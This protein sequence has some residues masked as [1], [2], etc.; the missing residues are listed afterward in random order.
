MLWFPSHPQIHLIIT[1]LWLKPLLWKDS[2]LHFVGLKVNLMQ[3]LSLIVY[4][5][6]F[7]WQS[8]LGI[9]L[10]FYR[11]LR[12]RGFLRFF[13]IALVV[14]CLFVLLSRFLVFIRLRF[15]LI[16][17]INCLELILFGL[18]TFTGIYVRMENFFFLDCF[19]E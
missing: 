8:S 2:L 13:G 1:L 15:R 18:L 4:A 6:I 9:L 19:L 16:M 11:I 10:I 14:L 3:F 5:L 17:E 7:F 12:L